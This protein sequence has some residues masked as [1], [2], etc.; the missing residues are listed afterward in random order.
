MLFKNLYRNPFPFSHPAL[1]I[2]TSSTDL[3]NIIINTSKQKHKLYVY[4]RLSL[5]E[6]YQ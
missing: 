2:L 4:F 5:A 6:I 1:A 3:P